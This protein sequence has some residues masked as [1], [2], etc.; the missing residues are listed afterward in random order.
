[1]PTYT[2][3]RS[4]ADVAALILIAFMLAA[5]LVPALAASN[6]QE[7]KTQCIRRMRDLAVALQ[8]A[9]DVYKFFPLASTQPLDHPPGA[10][11]EK[12]SG[13]S[14][15]TRLLPFMEQQVLYDHLADKERSNK[16]RIPPFDPVAMTIDEKS[17]LAIMAEPVPEFICPNFAGS[18]I[19]DAAPEYAALP[20]DARPAVTSYHATA[21]SHFVNTEGLGRMLPPDQVGK[22]PY[23]GDGVIVFPGKVGDKLVTKGLGLRS[24]PDGTSNTLQFAESNESAYAAW[25]DGQTTWLVSAWPSNPDLPAPQAGESHPTLGWT[26]EQLT[27]NQ[28]TPGA[29]KGIDA[30]AEP[31]IYLPVGRWTGKAQRAWGASSNHPEGIGHAFADAHVTMLSRDIDPVVYLHL[32]TRSSREVIPEGALK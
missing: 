10:T 21:G 26:A 31:P 25:I 17:N 9:H 15:L 23:E 11:G 16:L 2:Q 27:K 19:A 8:N 20:A 1:M 12:P 6:A 32:T 22:R 5:L 3:F 7:D 29:Q 28:V 13:Y 4:R 14:W 30:K 24:I 18:T